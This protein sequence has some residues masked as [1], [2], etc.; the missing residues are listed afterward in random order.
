MLPSFKL[1]FLKTH[2]FAPLY[3]SLGI[4]T[5][6]LLGQEALSFLVEAS[7]Q[8]NVDLVHRRQEIKREGEHLLGAIL[9]EKIAL[10]DY[11]MNGGDSNLKS[12]E[13]GNDNFRNSIASLS[14][15][16]QDDSF[17]IKR[18]DEI[19][20]FYARW[21]VQ[22]VDKVFNGS[23]GL[24]DLVKLD[25]VQPLRV[26]V[27][28]IL[29][30]EKKLLTEHQQKLNLLNQIDIGLSGFNIIVVLAGVGINILLM[31]RR[32]EF[33]LKQLTEVGQSWGAGRLDAQFNYL[34]P[35]EIGRLTEVL[36]AMARDIGTRQERVQQRNQHLE[37][38]IGTLSHDLRTPLLANRSTLDR[39]SVV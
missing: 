4:L 11:A 8:Q 13:I 1:S 32:V 25:S 19:R 38:L 37:D 26:S 3:I 5:V 18:I 15:L 12:Y 6:L 23:L 20:N 28:D 14:E 31:R 33:P 22:L 10:R 30:Y 36:N 34:S 35:D 2:L 9:E 21:K 39:K 7:E 29:D 17:Q 27:R 16:V 24:E